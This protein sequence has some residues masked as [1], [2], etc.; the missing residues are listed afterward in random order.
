MGIHTARK[1][2][3]L[4]ILRVAPGLVNSAVLHTPGFPPAGVHS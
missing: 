1:C 4:L 2:S 3:R